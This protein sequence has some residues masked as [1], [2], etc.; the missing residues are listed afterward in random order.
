MPVD[1]VAAEVAEK[2]EPSVIDLIAMRS[3]SKGKLA[4]ERNG[5]PQSF[6]NG[7]RWIKYRRRPSSPNNSF[8]GNEK[9]TLD[10]RE[11]FVRVRSTQF[12]TE[13]WPVTRDRVMQMLPTLSY[14]C[15]RDSRSIKGKSLRRLNSCRYSCRYQCL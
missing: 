3:K 6:E 12:K 1:S 7:E 5:V 9:W 8:T 2:G 10:A 4:N 11:Q 15:K 14:R 13:C